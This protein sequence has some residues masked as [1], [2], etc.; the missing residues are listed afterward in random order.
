MKKDEMIKLL[1]DKYG[2]ADDE[3]VDKNGNFLTNKKLQE[4]IDEKE[5]E[6]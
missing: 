5:R 3:L 2:V 1:K 6:Q 4:M